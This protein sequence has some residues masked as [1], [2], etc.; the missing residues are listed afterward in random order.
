MRLSTPAHNK[1]SSRHRTTRLA[2]FSHPAKQLFHAEELSQADLQQHLGV[3]GPVITRIVK[4]MEAEGLVTRR[5]DPKDNRYTLVAMKPEIRAQR[6][7]G[8]MSNFREVLGAHLMAGLNEEDRANLLRMIA[9]IAANAS[10]LRE[11]GLDL[12]GGE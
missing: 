1:E 8:G 12:M 9:Q 2:D 7:S 6:Y 3:E 4:Q 10:A 11:A 5:A